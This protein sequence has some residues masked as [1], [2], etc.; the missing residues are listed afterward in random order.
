M[1][2][3]YKKYKYQFEYISDNDV[4]RFKD[5]A[6]LK[7]PENYISEIIT[8]NNTL[9]LSDLQNINLYKPLINY[10]HHQQQYYYYPDC[11]LLNETINI[12]SIL[13]L[14]KR[15]DN[16][17]PCVGL[18]NNTNNKV[19]VIQG[20]Y[21]LNK[22]EEIHNQQGQGQA[23]NINIHQQQ[24]QGYDQLKNNNAGNG[25]FVRNNN[26]QFAGSNSNHS[27][28]NQFKQANQ[29]I[30]EM[31][32]QI[33]IILNLIIDF[34]VIRT[35]RKWP[36]NKN[37]KY[38]KY[39]PINNEWI[40]KFMDY[41]KLSSLYTN[42]IIHKTL[43]N[44]VFNTDNISVLSN[45]DIIENTKI[46]KDFMDI[47]TSFSMIIPEGK[48]AVSTSIHPNK[49]SISDIFYH[50]NFSLVSEK[51]MKYLNYYINRDTQ[52]LYYYCYFGD[53][54][55]IVVHNGAPTTFLILIYYLDQSYK[56]IPEIFFRYYGETEFKNSIFLLQE[57]G[58]LKFYQYYL[59][60][61]DNN[62]D[63]VSPIFDKENKEIGYAYKYNP[64]VTD[65]SFYI[66][67]IIDNNYKTMLKLYFNYILL[68]SKTINQK[69]ERSYLLINSEF[70]KKYKDYYEYPA[71]EQLLYKNNIAQQASKNIIDNYNYALNDKMLALII[72]NLPD[73]INQKFIEKS[74]NKVQIGNISEAPT[75]KGISN[76]DIFYYDE[77]EL[78]DKELYS[79]IFKKNNIGIYGECYFVN[80][81]ICIKMPTQINKKKSTQIYLFGRIHS[82][83][84]FQADYLLEY[85]SANDFIKN[86]MSRNSTGGFDK[87]I[88][89]FKFLNNYIE[90]LTEYDNKNLGLIYNIEKAPQAPVPP[91][92]IPSYQ[93][94]I[95]PPLIGLKNV[96][97]TCYMNAT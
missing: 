16:N 38:E 92:P 74:K 51:V 18:Y 22:K 88:S 32:H 14:T 23:N 48:Y 66:P 58:F 76:F 56:I 95:K 57:N 34:K 8:K 42:Q 96:G 3:I 71:L 65:F 89:Y 70:F 12:N 62:K 21:A 20:N 75:V 53:N 31:K 55:I 19:I 61:K 13:Q 84:I 94:P 36:L 2:K 29:M 6:L 15:I 78:I 82:Y 69:Q 1:G 35:K 83:H 85:N 60:F 54:K 10:A 28:P 63:F 44:I 97:A 33:K 37:S 50:K 47:V 45:D 49:I 91:G 43:D 77:F 86:F 5:E 46:Q 93:D 87:Y 59:M 41:Y 67:Y 79:L 68:K 25:Q 72:K 90:E 64:S 39:Y 11:N 24:M 26:Q 7:L 52:P 9:I 40:S 17:N 30:P 27:N 81:Y 4:H 73:N 80:D